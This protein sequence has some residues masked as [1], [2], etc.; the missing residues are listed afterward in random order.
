MKPKIEVMF[1]FLLKWMYSPRSGADKNHPRQKN[2]DKTSDQTS[3]RTKT[4]VCMHVLL[5]IGGP[6]CVTKCDRGGGQ[7]WSKIA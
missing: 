6:R 4:Y 5:N 1:S 3:P 7:N 2:P